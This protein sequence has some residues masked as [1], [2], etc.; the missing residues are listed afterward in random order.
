[1]ATSQNEGKPLHPAPP[2][3]CIGPGAV[4]LIHKQPGVG[5]PAPARPNEVAKF[6]NLIM[7]HK[8]MKT[9]AC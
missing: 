6:M 4:Q 5:G 1:M 9:L 2:K 7:L 8:M 3:F